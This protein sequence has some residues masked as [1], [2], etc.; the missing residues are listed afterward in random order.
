[1]YLSAVFAVS[2][3]CFSARFLFFF[4]ARFD[5]FFFVAVGMAAIVH[6]NTPSATGAAQKTRC[7]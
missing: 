1:M 7:R 4:S 3:F 6:A 2:Q 5:C